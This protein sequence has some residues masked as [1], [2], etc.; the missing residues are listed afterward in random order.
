MIAR[1]WRT[2]LIAGRGKAYEDFARDISLPMF[3]QQPGF[4][5]CAMMRN[6]EEG[7]VMTFWQDLDAVTALEHSSSYQS[8]VSRIIKA[9][10]LTGAQST[11]V[12]EVHLA[13]MQIKA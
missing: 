8:V 6:E 3:R 4:L 11:D 13:A 10:L 7:L 9:D 5:G 1:L 2:G 12:K